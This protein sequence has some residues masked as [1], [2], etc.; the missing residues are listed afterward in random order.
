MNYK[1]GSIAITLNHT[2]SACVNRIWY[3]DWYY[4]IDVAFVVG[5]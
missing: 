1:S 4:Q 2:K 5:N 3:K